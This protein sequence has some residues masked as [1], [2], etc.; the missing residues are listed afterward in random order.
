MMWR[1]FILLLVS[2]AACVA[3][4]CA[5]KEAPAPERIDPAVWQSPH[6]NWVR[7]NQPV[8]VADGIPPLVFQTRQTE[9]IR[10]VDSTIDKVVAQ[11][12]VQAFDF[13]RV[14]DSGVFVG[15]QCI[16][17]GPLWTDHKYTILVEPQKEKS[18]PMDTDGHR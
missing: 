8:P 2:P 17:A 11:M 9:P 16:V 18:P 12:T 6:A 14:V 1:L 4:G 7:E 5:R 10:V 13:V 15:E 3:G